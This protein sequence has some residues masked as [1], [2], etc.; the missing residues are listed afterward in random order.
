MKKR[1]ISELDNE[2]VE[3]IVTMAQEE[4][5]PYDVIKEEFGIVENDVNELMRKK[6][7]KE[8]FEL[9]KKKAIAGKPKPKPLKFNIIE[10]DDLD[11]KYYIKNKFD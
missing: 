1:K 11:A 2:T 6:L 10:D 8:N 5:K 9:W 7:N 3:R 4:K